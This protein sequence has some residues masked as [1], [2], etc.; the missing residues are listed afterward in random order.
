MGKN[1]E[2]RHIPSAQQRTRERCARRR[3]RTHEVRSIISH[4]TKHDV[5]SRSLARTADLQLRRGDELSIDDDIPGECQL[6][7]YRRI[8]KITYLG[9]LDALISVLA[10][11]ARR[12]ART[13][14]LPSQPTDLTRG[15]V[16]EVY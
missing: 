1:E 10:G 13:S 11:S 2:Q 4:P 7:D 14:A 6:E 12:H 5:R 9:A 16:K 8:T 3:V 15:P